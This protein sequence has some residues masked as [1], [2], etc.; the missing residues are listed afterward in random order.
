MKPQLQKHCSVEQ[1][2]LHSPLLQTR[3]TLAAELVLFSLFLSLFLPSTHHSHHRT[4]LLVIVIASL[5]LRPS[6]LP[7]PLLADHAAGFSGSS[8][9][10]FAALF[11]FA[12]LF[13]VSVHSCFPFFWFKLLSIQFPRWNQIAMEINLESLAFDID[14]HPSNNLLAVGLITGH[15][16][17]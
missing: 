12:Y 3:G 15:L 14:F 7:S 8:R 9:S 16:H 2:R 17:L 4:P 11:G 5:L 6:C 10:Q 1:G 13:I